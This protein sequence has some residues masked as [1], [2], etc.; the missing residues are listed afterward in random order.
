[1]FV[2]PA[3]SLGPMIGVWFLSSYPYQKPLEEL[4][5]ETV[6]DIQGTIFSLICWIPIIC[7]VLQLVVWKYYSL[8]DNH[9]VEV[10]SMLERKSRGDSEEHL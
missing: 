2:K 6:Q 5:I 7:G 9:L 10:K 8:H 4:D 1:M 3:Q